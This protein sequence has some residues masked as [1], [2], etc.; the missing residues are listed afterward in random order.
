MQPESYLIDFVRLKS[1]HTGE[2]IH[3][4]TECIIDRFNVKEK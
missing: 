4:A 2:N 1:P 3:Q